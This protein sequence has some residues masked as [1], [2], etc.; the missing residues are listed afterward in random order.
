MEGEF[1]QPLV[2]G[3]AAEPDCNGGDTECSL[4]D[5]TDGDNHV[6]TAKLHQK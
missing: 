5:T 1:D 6:M 3:K 2:I 4:E